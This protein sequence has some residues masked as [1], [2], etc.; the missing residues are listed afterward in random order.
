MRDAVEILLI[1]DNPADQLL[2]RKLMS[3]AGVRARFTIAED[4]EEAMKCAEG[5]C[6]ADHPDL[7]LLDL[8]LPKVGGHEVLEFIVSRGFG[9]PVAVLTGSSA[10]EDVERAERLGVVDYIVK[11]VGMNEFDETAVRLRGLIGSLRA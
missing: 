11:P 4:G 1:E 8:K 7:V 5:W 10:K 6:G 3:A 2:A 9:V